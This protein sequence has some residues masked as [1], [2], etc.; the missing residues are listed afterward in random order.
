MKHMHRFWIKL[1]TQLGSPNFFLPLLGLLATLAFSGSASAAGT[2]KICVAWEYRYSDQVTGED[3]LLHDPG[4]TTGKYK[5]NYSWAA[6]H[7]NGTEIV[8]SA[9]LGSDGCMSVP[10]NAGTYRVWLLP[11]LKRNSSR[12]DIF[13]AKGLPLSWLI[14]DVT[15]PGRSSGTETVTVRVGNGVVS[16]ANVAAVA[17]RI[18]DVQ[19]AALKPNTTYTIYSQEPPD[20]DDPNSAWAIN[21]E[22]WI[23][24]HWTFTTVVAHEIAHTI[25]YGLWGSQRLRTFLPRTT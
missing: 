15:L 2:Y 3:Y 20:P 17:A 10:A 12:I 18:M 5:A 21:L 13:V 4:L 6:L 1:R 8:P 22:A 7:R 11:T 19:S 16:M 23:G 14:K 9:Y 25:Q 24:R